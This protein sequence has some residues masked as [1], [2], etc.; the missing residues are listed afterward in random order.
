MCRDPCEARLPSDEGAPR[1]AVR[2]RQGRAG[3]LCERLGS[4]G[5]GGRSRTWGWGRELRGHGEEDRAQGG[6][7]SC[8]QGRAAQRPWVCG[9]CSTTC[10][11]E[12][13]G[14]EPRLDLRAV[15][16]TRRALVI[17]ARALQATTRF[18][19]EGPWG[20]GEAGGGPRLGGVGPNPALGF[21]PLLP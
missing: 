3:T 20:P 21:S 13:P 4:R 10:L 2:M 6:G 9:V 18:L 12:R 15:Q 1:A 14:R 17:A 8:A 7:A 19:S 11:A 16:A 5:C